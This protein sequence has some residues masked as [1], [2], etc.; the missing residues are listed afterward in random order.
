M[1]ADVSSCA[2]SRRSLSPLKA[3]PAEPNSIDLLQQELEAV[4]KE[5][6]LAG[7]CE[8]ASRGVGDEV[9]LLLKCGVL[10]KKKK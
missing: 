2:P 1:S 3:T 5:K 6:I 10:I 8:K 7:P 4:K 9:V